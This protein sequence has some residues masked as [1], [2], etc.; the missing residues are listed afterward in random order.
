MPTSERA[1]A[2]VGWL[3]LHPGLHPRVEVA[4]QLWPEAATAR[5]NLRAAIWTVRQA[6]GPAGSAL[7]GQRDLVG[8]LPDEIW[9]DASATPVAGQALPE[10]TLLPGLGDDWLDEERAR[11]RRRQ[12]TR[13][14]TLAVEAEADGDLSAAARW[15]AEGARLAPLDE[16]VHRELLR[17]LVANGDRAAAT[18]TAREFAERLRSELGVDPSPATRAVQSGLQ[19]G[20]PAAERTALFGRSA[21]LKSMLAAWRE[22]ADGHGHVLG[23]T[24]EAGI[25]ETS[26]LAELARRVRT[27]GARTAVGAGIDVGGE[28]PFAAW[29][30]LARALVATVR[31]VPAGFGWPRELNRLSEELGAR[32]GQPEAP[33]AVAAPELERLRVFEAILRLV[34]WSASDRPLLIA[35][36]DAHRAD[37]ASLRLTAHIARRVSALP[38]LLVLTRR[39]RPARAELDALLT[40]LASRKVPAAEMVLGP[41][42]DAAIA[43]LATA[44]AATLAQESL[45]SDG[46]QRVVW[47]AEGNPLFAVESARALAAGQLA[48]PPNLRTAVRLMVSALPE[49]AQV[50]ARLLAVAGRPLS[51]PELDSVTPL[52]Q[53]RALAEEAVLASGLV[54][55]ATGGL[56]YRH[57]LLREAA[58]ADIA[59]PA[60]LHD[61]LASALVRSDHAGIGR[62]LEAAGR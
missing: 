20:E 57:A 11:Y 42:D 7:A 47:A 26:L 41:I 25:G 52:Q 10:G 43:A 14:G 60:P 50:L 15:A 27:G 24:G 8:L 49:P 59:D 53:P 19:K 16:A 37:R 21:E 30:E 38:V 39:D 36:D 29:L 34:E 18:V 3:A 5:A 55:A 61:R 9:V 51:R 32:L 45:P 35:L 62:H 28:T 13:L 22:A 17:L 40:D 31:R 58:Y 23:L 33:V 2:L 54:V 46:L 48:P 44:T 1:R 56:G 6:W 12:L 4:A